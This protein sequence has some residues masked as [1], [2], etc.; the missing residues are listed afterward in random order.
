MR[1]RKAQ[2]WTASYGSLMLLGGDS[3]NAYHQLLANI[4]AW[5]SLTDWEVWENGAMCLWQAGEPVISRLAVSL[6]LDWATVGPCTPRRWEYTCDGG[7]VCNAGGC[8]KT[9]RRAST[10]RKVQMR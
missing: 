9:P 5:E 8:V 2:I 3:R 7:L 4:L 10:E 1:A 6:L